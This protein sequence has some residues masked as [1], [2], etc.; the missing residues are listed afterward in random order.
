MLKI[1]VYD[2]IDDLLYSKNMSRRQFATECNIPTSTFQSIMERRSGISIE[3]LLVICE[4]LGIRLWDLF[5]VSTTD[6]HSEV[7][8]LMLRIRSLVEQLANEAENNGMY[9][10]LFQDNLLS[11]FAPQKIEQ[12]CKKAVDRCSLLV[13]NKELFKTDDCHSLNGNLISLFLDIDNK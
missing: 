7:D 3:M 9:D 2:K 5:P 4:K 10:A 8:A 13:K 6:K 11:A 1:T 12:E